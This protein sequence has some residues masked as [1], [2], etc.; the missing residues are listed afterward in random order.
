M[1]NN[2]EPQ[3]NCQEGSFYTFQILAPYV[4]IKKNI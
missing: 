1:A 3:Q 4:N 2:K